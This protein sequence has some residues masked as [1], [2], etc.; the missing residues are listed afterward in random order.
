MDKIILGKGYFVIV[1]ASVSQRSNLFKISGL[2]RQ[3][4]ASQ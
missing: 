3:K 2:L 4:N 1:I